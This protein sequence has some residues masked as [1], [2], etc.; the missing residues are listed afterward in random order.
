M[1]E[2]DSVV[3]DRN[4]L[5]ES[6]QSF[7]FHFA[8]LLSETTHLAYQCAVHKSRHKMKIFTIY[9]FQR[10]LCLR[11]MESSISSVM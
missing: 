4:L 9:I 8:S 7:M 3:G 1:D 2:H 6:E 11:R 5:P 10:H